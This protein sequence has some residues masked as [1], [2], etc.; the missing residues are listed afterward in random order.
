MSA[1]LPSAPASIIPSLM[2]SGQTMVVDGSSIMDQTYLQHAG[3]GDPKVGPEIPQLLEFPTGEGEEGLG[4]G[5]VLLYQ[6]IY[7]P[8]VTVTKEIEK[9][10]TGLGWH[11]KNR[12]GYRTYLRLS[13]M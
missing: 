6:P 8:Y 2:V 3:G 4:R 13:T 7:L 10:N 12:N 1:S 5:T 11:W 9:R